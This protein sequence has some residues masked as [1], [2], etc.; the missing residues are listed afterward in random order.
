[1]VGAC[2]STLECSCN[3]VVAVVVA[4]VTRSGAMALSAAWLN[5]QHNSSPKPKGEKRKEDNNDDVFF[6]RG[7]FKKPGIRADCNGV[8]LFILM[9]FINNYLLKSTKN[10][11]FD[12][13]AVLTKGQVLIAFSQHTGETKRIS[14]AIPPVQPHKTWHCRHT[15][16]SNG[17]PAMTPVQRPS[18][19][20]CYTTPVPAPVVLAGNC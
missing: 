18:P 6:M 8:M 20:W 4:A 1:M 2:G 7:V 12:R 13:A 19:T 3:G 15:L 10:P 11:A 16:A 14:P 5:E 9:L 17:P